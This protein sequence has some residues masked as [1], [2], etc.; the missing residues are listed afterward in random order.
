MTNEQILTFLTAGRAIF[1]LV[2][3]KTGAHFTYRI[4]AGRNPGIYF[5]SVK[6]GSDEWLYLGMYQPEAGEVIPT[7]NGTVSHD[8]P[9]FAGLNWFLQH[10]GDSRVEFKHV[11]RCCRCGRELTHPTSIDS[12]IGPECANKLAAPRAPLKGPRPVTPPGVKAPLSGFH[13]RQPSLAQQVELAFGNDCCVA[14]DEALKA[15]DPDP[16]VIIPLL[17]SLKPGE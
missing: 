10:I 7:R 1:T 16:N 11:G 9:S 15:R 12:G 6:R 8:S 13:A 4:Q 5:A 3:R 2:S 14:L 17:L